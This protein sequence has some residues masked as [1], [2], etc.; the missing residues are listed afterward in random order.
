MRTPVKSRGVS[1]G[2]NAVCTWLIHQP[3]QQ[4]MAV[5]CMA[6]PRGRLGPLTPALLLAEIAQLAVEL[7]GLHLE[8]LDRLLGLGH[9]PFQLRGARAISQRVHAQQRLKICGWMQAS[10]GSWLCGDCHCLH[11]VCLH[12]LQRLQP[13]TLSTASC[14]SV[15]VSWTCL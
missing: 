11:T 6:K 8:L 2:Q 13:R 10:A 3:R 4:D 5:P 14:C 12:T 7:G 15:M 9:T 1:D